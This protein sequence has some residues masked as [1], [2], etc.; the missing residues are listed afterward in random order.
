MDTLAELA[1]ALPSTRGAWE[2][3]I[4][5]MCATSGAARAAYASVRLAVG[6]PAFYSRVRRYVDAGEGGVH[7][8]STGKQMMRFAMPHPVLKHRRLSVRVFASG[9]AEVAGHVHAEI[10]E[11]ADAVGALARRAGAEARVELVTVQCC[12][13][14]WY[15][16]F[17]VD[18]AALETGWETLSRGPPV[19]VRRGLVSACVYGNGTVSFVAKC[20]AQLGR[21]YGELFEAMLRS[22]GR[23]E[24]A[25]PLIKHEEERDHESE[26]GGSDDDYA[27]RGRRADAARSTEPTKRARRAVVVRKQGV[28]VLGDPRRAGGREAARGRERRAHASA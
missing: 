28:A 8:A 14:Y 13:V 2:T 17:D 1:L 3:V 7:A 25:C 16:G 4:G 24:F 10:S 5:S 27:P 20:L 6:G 26:A 19:R 15:T 22:P 11:L 9:A 21:A 18:L 23:V 12:Q